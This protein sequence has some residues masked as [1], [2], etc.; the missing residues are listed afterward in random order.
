MKIKSATYSLSGV[1]AEQY[2]TTGLPEI[3]LVGRSNVGK[4]SLINALL[5]RRSLART[6]SQPGK[7]Q[8]ANFYLINEAFYLVDLPGYGYAKT[9]KVERARFSSLVANYLENRETLRLVL[10]VIDLRHPP[11]ALD[12]DMFRYLHDLRRPRVVVANKL[13]KLKRSVVEKHQRQVL[14]NLSGLATQDLIL[15]SAATKQGVPELWQAVGTALQK[16]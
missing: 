8:T 10:Q 11:T 3:A 6:S 15:F 2:P 1:K 4:S 7:T 5:N 13:D 12:Q 9:S 14:A 16:E